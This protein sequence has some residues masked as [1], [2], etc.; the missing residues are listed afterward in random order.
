MTKEIKVTPW[1]VEGDVDYDRLIKE[2]GIKPI[3]KLPEVF[4]ENILFRRGTIFAHRD[5]QRILESI[6]DKKKFVM[7]TG[8]MPSGKFHLGHMILAQQMIFYQNLGAK[9]YIA[10]ADLEAYNARQKN[11]KE[12][13]EIA[14]DQYLKNY[15]ALGLKPENCDFYFQSERSVDAKKSN[16]YYRL[17]SNLS[18]Y[19]TFS[20]FK[21]VYGEISPGK[22]NASLL[23][24]ADMLHPQLKEFE[25]KALPIL[26]PVGIDQDPHLRIARDISK[27]YK[28]DKFI[29]LSSTYH[30]FLPSLKGG[31]KMS[32]SDE[33]SYIAMTDSPAEVKKKINKYAFSG[34]CETIEEHRKHGGNPDID[35]SFQYLKM[36][37]EPDDEKLKQ[38]YNDYKSGKMLTGELKKYLI[39]KIN[40]FLAEHQ[41]KRDKIAKKDIDGFIYKS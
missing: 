17:A 13:R 39:D 4:N 24:S 20:E 18:R 33:N 15:I 35:V 16:A 5:I 1:E 7:M 6:K 27:R 21:A 29:Q 9:L 25:G 34:G 8:L 10:V 38:I 11:L 3:S 12:L 30:A 31:A 26:I 32:S 41:K 23:Q 36:F 14:I 22:M 28:D 40:D 2:F 19:A 37:F